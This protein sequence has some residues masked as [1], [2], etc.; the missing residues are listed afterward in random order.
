MNKNEPIDVGAL[1]NIISN[2][3]DGIINC[4]LPPFLLY[5]VDAESTWKEFEKCKVDVARRIRRDT[6]LGIEG[7]EERIRCW[8]LMATESLSPVT[9]G[10]SVPYDR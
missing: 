5:F 9:K 3:Y 10:D 8:T 1:E 4:L 7:A 2:Y 6:L